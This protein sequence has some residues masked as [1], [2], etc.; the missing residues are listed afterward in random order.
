MLKEGR[1]CFKQ[2]IQ[3]NTT[4]EKRA[5][6]T[7]Y[8]RKELIMRLIRVDDNSLLGSAEL[9]LADYHSCLKRTKFS[10]NIVTA[11]AAH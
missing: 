7:K 5:G 9:D 4:L 6:M 8:D 10:L 11:A 1:A 2:K 3:M